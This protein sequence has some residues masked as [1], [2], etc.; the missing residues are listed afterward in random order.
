MNNIN[1]KE[2]ELNQNEEDD[3][4]YENKSDELLIK[5]L[6]KITTITTNRTVKRDFDGEVLFNVT[7]DDGQIDENYQFL[8]LVI[9]DV[10]LHEGIIPI[11]KNWNLKA[12]KFPFSKRNCLITNEKT[13]P[14]SL[15]SEEYQ[16]Y[17]QFINYYLI[18]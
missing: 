10:T 17:Q 3:I 8:R 1:Y 16:N 4:I 15:F 14:G 5:N 13:V 7:F 6:K 2:E 12:K 18:E 9:P 11:L